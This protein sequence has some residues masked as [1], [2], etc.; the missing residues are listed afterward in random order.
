MSKRFQSLAVILAIASSPTL[1]SVEGFASTESR[2]P[3]E[4]CLATRALELEVSGIEVSEVIARA[5]RACSDAKSG[6]TYASASEISQKVRLAVVQQRSNA[7]NTLRR[8]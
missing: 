1:A 2:H 7:R 6:L 4:S 8:G 5:E 3:Y